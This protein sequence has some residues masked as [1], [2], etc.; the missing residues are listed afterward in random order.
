MPGEKEALDLF[1][2]SQSLTGIFAI[3]KKFGVPT[4]IKGTLRSEVLP[5]AGRI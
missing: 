2:T 3:E 4:I 5:L 1:L